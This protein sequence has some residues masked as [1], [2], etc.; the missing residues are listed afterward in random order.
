MKQRSECRHN[1]VVLGASR[2]A[3]VKPIGDRAGNEMRPRS[4]P[5]CGRV[6]CWRGASAPAPALKHTSPFFARAENGLTIAPTALE[7]RPT[8]LKRSASCMGLGIRLRP[9]RFVLYD[10]CEYPR[11]VE[12]RVVKG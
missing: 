11:L 9:W 8:G 4:C 12:R 3:F 2:A 10:L 7:G 6:T 1:N 5:L